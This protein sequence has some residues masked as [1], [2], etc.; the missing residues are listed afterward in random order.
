MKD[1]LRLMV[2]LSILIIGFF[3][4]IILTMPYTSALANIVWKLSDNNPFIGIFLSAL[5]LAGIFWFA[6]RF[7]VILD[8]ILY[9]IYNTVG[10]VF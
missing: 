6:S 3:S 7:N 10:R 2:S 9:G 1:F 8:K 4:V 5:A